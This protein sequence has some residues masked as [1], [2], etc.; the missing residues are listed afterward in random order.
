MRKSY[1]QS[2]QHFYL[3]GC[4][5][6]HKN[7]FCL[8]LCIGQIQDSLIGHSKGFIPGMTLYLGVLV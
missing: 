5:N 2:F 6:Y 4:Q 7:V 1:S 3:Q 8:A